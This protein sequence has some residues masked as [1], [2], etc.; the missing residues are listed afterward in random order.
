[1]K[2]SFLFKKQHLQLTNDNNINSCGRELQKIVE[3]LTWDKK[4]W[5]KL[6]KMK[7]IKARSA[8]LQSMIQMG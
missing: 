5:L 8:N 1:M 7:S 3:N 6:F 4:I 2:F